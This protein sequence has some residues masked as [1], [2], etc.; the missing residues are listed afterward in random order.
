MDPMNKAGN[1]FAFVS[2]KF[3]LPKTISQF[4]EYN[5]MQSNFTYSKTR[6]SKHDVIKV[7]KTIVKKLILR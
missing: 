4:G 7:M 3:Y 6:F 2:K 5:N 1:Y